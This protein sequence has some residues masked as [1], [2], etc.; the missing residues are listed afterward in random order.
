M[1]FEPVQWIASLCILMSVQLMSVQKTWAQ[2]PAVEVVQDLFTGLRARD[3]LVIQ[4]FLHPEAVL[5]R[6]SRTDQGVLETRVVDGQMFISEVGAGGIPYVERIW[7]PEV[8]E[9]GEI[10][11]VVAPYDFWLEGQLSHCG[12]DVITLMETEKGQWQ[13]VTLMYTVDGKTPEICKQ[14][15]PG[16]PSPPNSTEQ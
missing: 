3:S 8:V 2:H 1:K 13:V 16:Q 11:T 6:W 14:R 12:V 4:P 10:V 9:T 15:F 5:Q 7:S